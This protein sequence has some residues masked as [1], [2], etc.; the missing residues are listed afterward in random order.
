MSRCQIP[1]F[2]SLRMGIAFLHRSA[3]VAE[4]PCHGFRRAQQVGKAGPGARARQPESDAAPHGKYRA[5]A[6][7]ASLGALPQ[8]KGTFIVH[9]GSPLA[10]VRSNAP[11]RSAT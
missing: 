6:H 5:V 11:G 3:A 9:D 4:V 7:L 2:L 10:T 1:D 8:R